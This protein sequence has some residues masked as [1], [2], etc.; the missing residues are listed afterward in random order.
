MDIK[1][2]QNLM[3]LAQKEANNICSAKKNIE[4]T[5][6]EFVKKYQ[7]DEWIKVGSWR[8][9]RISLDAFYSSQTKY[10]LK[11]YNIKNL[12]PIK[13][14]SIGYDVFVAQ[15]E[16]NQIRETIF[17]KIDSG[18]LRFIN[19]FDKLQE[20]HRNELKKELVLLQEEKIIDKKLIGKVFNKILSILVV[21]EILR[22][23]SNFFEEVIT[24]RFK[25]LKITNISLIDLLEK[26]TESDTYKFN[27]ELAKISLNK[28]FSDQ[29]ISKLIKKYGYLWQYFLSGESYSKASILKQI[30][31]P[32]HNKKKPQKYY[33]K[34]K[35]LKELVSLVNRFSVVR[36]LNN[37][38]TNKAIFSLKP[39]FKKVAGEKGYSYRKI[40]S[41]PL[42][43][44]FKILNNEKP[45]LSNHNCGNNV[46]I[47]STDKK[48]YI[49]A[50]E[51]F[52]RFKKKFID[53]KI[54]NN[55]EIKGISTSGG[56]VRGRVK[57]IMGSNDFFKFKKN[58]I[59][60]CSMTDPNYIALIKK[61]SA[62]ITDIG[63]ILCHA[64][65]VSREMNK[66]CII[67]A[68]NATKIL[69]D[70]DLVEVDANKGV[71]KILK[72]ME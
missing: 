37:E 51:Y 44:F 71:I 22:D 24:K 30:E 10:F 67:G 45:T 65:I 55:K 9:P 6:D 25:R 32:N 11:K 7:K 72:T 70:G 59:L 3:C 43:D 57:I 42:N 47:I 35:K 38:I 34:D 13:Y 54:N 23:M 69:K 20:K 36:L 64:A 62:F 21:F 15:K 63:G 39:Y 8:V 31:Q 19:K 50:Q 53:K 48:N 1:T 61:A 2:K 14:F 33:I 52:K 68:K 41:Y 27:K 5:Y 4:I 49:L 17:K 16:L 12:Q 18:N 29:K 58:D 40:L 46:A 26:D 56:V 60:V 28:K 66:P